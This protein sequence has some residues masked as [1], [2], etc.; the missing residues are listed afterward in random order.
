MAGPL[1]PA[2]WHGPPLDGHWHTVLARLHIAWR[3]RGENRSEA[4]Q[5]AGL[6]RDL[7]EYLAYRWTVEE[8]AS[9]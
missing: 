9:V 4:Y 5:A 6:P 1:V 3:R 8:V 7:A 2:E